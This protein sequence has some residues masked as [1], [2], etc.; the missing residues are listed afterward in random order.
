MRAR[1]AVLRLR[2]NV[3]SLSARDHPVRRVYGLVKEQGPK[4]RGV[5]IKGVTYLETLASEA[6]WP[7]ILG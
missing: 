6:K 1:A 3:L 4:G 2:N 7:G 5:T